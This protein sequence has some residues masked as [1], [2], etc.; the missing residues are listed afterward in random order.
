MKLAVLPNVVLAFEKVWKAN[1]V[2]LGMAGVFN[3][4]CWIPMVTKVTYVDRMDEFIETYSMATKQAKVDGRVVNISIQTIGKY[5]KI[6]TNGLTNKLLHA[7]T[8]RSSLRE[9]NQRIESGRLT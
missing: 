1:Q 5:L 2:K 3:Y 6:P 7:L 4:P 8:I 9:N